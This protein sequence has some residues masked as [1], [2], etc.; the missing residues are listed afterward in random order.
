MDYSQYSIE[1]LLHQL[2]TAYY[3]A[4]RC[5]QRHLESPYQRIWNNYQTAQQRRQGI[6]DEISKRFSVLS[7]PPFNK[8]DRVLT[9]SSAFHFP[10]KEGVVVGFTDFWVLVRIDGENSLGKAFYDYELV[11]V[12]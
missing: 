8:G 12:A 5:Y 3:E 4:K 9:T 1:S 2:E 7:K 11:K 6:R 10:N